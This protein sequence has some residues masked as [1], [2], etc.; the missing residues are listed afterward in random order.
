MTRVLTIARNDFLN[1]RRSMLLWGVSGL[2]LVVMLLMFYFEGHSSEPQLKSVISLM[3]LIGVLIIPLI[4]LI[5]S[6]LAIAGERESGSIKF[7]LGL[8]TTRLELV[9]GKFLS[10][11]G[12]VAGAVVLSVAVSG[13]YGIV[14]YPSIPFATLLAFTGLTLV[15]VTAYVAVAIGISAST[16]ARSRAMGAAIG[17][18]FVF[19]VFWLLN[20]GS[21]S[22]VGVIRFIVEDTLGFNLARKTELFI[23]ALSPGTAYINSLGLL[24][25]KRFGI[26]PTIQGASPFYLE[27][28]FMLV[29]LL[30]WII[31][32]LGLGYWRFSRSNLG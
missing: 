29:I 10:R 1:V 25:P 27:S 5:A 24:Y 19:N 26:T 11:V 20:L 23:R 15:F 14:T 28:W 16:A 13:L 12:I 6:Y 21:F 9:V 4:A 22:T 3:T 7:R 2:Y 17:Y 31:V 30:V 32:P 18:F 8:P